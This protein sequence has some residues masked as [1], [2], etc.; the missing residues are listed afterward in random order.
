MLQT[1][2]SRHEAT[3]SFS[4]PLADLRPPYARPTP[5][6]RYNTDALPGLALDTESSGRGGARRGGAGRAI[7]FLEVK[8]GPCVTSGLAVARRGERKGKWRGVAGP[9]RDQEKGQRPL[10]SSPAPLSSLLSP[11]FRFVFPLWS[12]QELWVRIW[13]PP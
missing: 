8:G 13:T 12:P 9:G 6:L 10:L 11:S 5:A 7:P 2:K 4:V 3:P 1:S